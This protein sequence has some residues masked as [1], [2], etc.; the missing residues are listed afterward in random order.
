MTED[1]G[2]KIE[3][4]SSIPHPLSS[5]SRSWRLSLRL[6]H[7]SHKQDRAGLRIADR[8]QE[9]PVGDETETLSRLAH[10]RNR[11]SNRCRGRGF[12]AF[13]VDF[14]DGLMLNLGDEEIFFGANAAE[15]GL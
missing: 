7:R 2:S 5:Y 14:D 15:I 3:R 12:R 1:G 6:H 8:H 10:R 11:D 4:R 9:G 13:F